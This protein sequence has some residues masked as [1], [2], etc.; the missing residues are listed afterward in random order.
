VRYRGQF[1]GSSNESGRCDEEDGMK[2]LKS[3]SDQE[4]ARALLA[5]VQPL[6]SQVQ[7]LAKKYGAIAYK[8]ARIG[9][10]AAWVVLQRLPIA[11]LSFAHALA[12]ADY[13]EELRALHADRLSTP[14][15]GAASATRSA[16]QAASPTAAQLAGADKATAQAAAAKPA[17]RAPVKLEPVELEKAPPDSALLLLSLLQKEG[18]F[19]D[20]MQEDV[21]SY[22][23]QE[24]GA[25]AR[26]VHQGCGKVLNEYLHIA[27]VR[28]ETEGAQVT[29][30]PGFNPSEVRP[31]GQVVGEPPFT[32]A[33]VH[34]GWKAT[35]IQLPKIASSHD[36]RILAAAEVEL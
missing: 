10:Q 8:Y 33:L 31:T 18:R 4:G 20:F 24:V 6:L 22:S 15:L 23:D 13:A 12:D 16:A 36:L 3:L 32:G 7:A 34:R 19:I 5:K 11:S 27:P 26:V 17:E 30:E 1:S 29:L 9:A 2:K 21:G 28:S 25:A 14:G 35:D